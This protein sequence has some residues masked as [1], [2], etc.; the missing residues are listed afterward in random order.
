MI[1]RIF[2]TTTASL[3]LLVLSAATHAQ[4]M[5]AVPEPFKGAN[6][7]S[8]FS[9]KYDDVNELLKITVVITGFSSREKADAPSG[10]TGTRMKQKVKRATVNEG[11]RFY[12]E[13]FQGDPDATAFLQSVRKSLEIVPEQ[14]PL[15]AFSRNEQLAYWLNLYNITLID[16]VSKIYPKRS[17]KKILVGK[18][19][20]LTKKILTV[21]GVP[22]SLDDI[23]FI[24]RTNFNSDP[25]IIYGLYQGIIGGPNIRKVAY[26]GSNVYQALQSNAEE[27]VNS[28]R[29]TYSKDEKTFRV[30]SLYER[31]AVFFA[32]DEALKKH[33]LR[34]LRGS[35][36][37]ELKSASRIKRDINDWSITDLHGSSRSLGGSF[38]N[39][40]AALADSVKGTQPGQTQ[41]SSVSVNHSAS[42]STV[43]DKAPSDKRFSADL[44]L[45]L[46]ELNAR[47]D[48]ANRAG[49]TV[50]VEELGT[51]EVAPT[52]P[53]KDDNQ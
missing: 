52:E 13:A 48:Q 27:F 44:M 17:L 11:N 18:K 31:D 24:L 45:R 22:L 47:S 5:N 12:Y 7:D 9:I 3:V 43:L 49:A 29:G 26:S 6:P 39:S 53:D 15:G 16:E 2:F 14:V 50:T 23:E 46:Q 33:L 4:K 35:E 19:S 34:F 40:K 1:N 51:V 41:G 42:S 25:L 10:E 20:I 32:N 36:V 38:A 28:N 8:T 21:A 30:S 37:D